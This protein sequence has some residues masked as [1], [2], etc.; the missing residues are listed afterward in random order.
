MNIFLFD[1]E[2]TG[3]S[4]ES[5]DVCQI[6]WQCGYIDEGTNTLHMD[7]DTQESMWIKGGTVPD[8]DF[9]KNAGITQEKVDAGKHPLSA[10]DYVRNIILEN[11][12]N[13]I[14]AHN[15]VFDARFL[16]TSL[17]KHGLDS[18]FLYEMQGHCTML[19]LTETVG[20]SGKYGKPKWPKLNEA[21]DWVRENDDEPSEVL[22]GIAFHDAEDDTKVLRVLYEYC[23]RKQL[24]LKQVRLC[25]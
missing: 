25:E 22:E 21:L 3:F 8:A 6:A 5:A 15:L 19:T 13:V 20:L 7:A 12:T 14:V 16:R 4:P 9:F 24:P 1:V 2:T 23:I 11:Q 17:A 10:F 18:T